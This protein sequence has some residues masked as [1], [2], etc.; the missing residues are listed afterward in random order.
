MKRSSLKEAT[1]A[2]ID[3]SRT[4]LAERQRSAQALVR[5]MNTVA[6]GLET[7]GADTAS[8]RFI[9]IVRGRTAEIERLFG[10]Q[11][12]VAGNFNL[13]LFGRTGAGK[14]TLIEALT[15]GDGE[16]VSHG[17]SDWTTKVE[18][19][20]WEYCKIYDTP[21]VN[22]WGRISKRA[23][24]ER[25]A[26][27]AVEVADFVLVCFDSQSQQASEFTK[28]ADWIHQ[29]NKPVVAVLNARNAVWRLPPRVPIGAARANL[30]RTVAEHAGNIQDELASVGLTGVPVVAIASK[31]ALFARA[32]SPF[33]GPDRE[34]LEL[35]REKYG[36]EKLEAW[37]NLPAL[38]DL[39]VRCVQDNAVAL[40]MGALNDQ[41][42]GVLDALAKGMDSAAMEAAEEADIVEAQTIEPL[43]KL[44]GYPSSQAARQPYVRAGVDRLGQLEDQRGPFQA[45]GNGEFG[46]FVG[47]RLTAELGALRSQSL[48]DAEE[49]VAC[50]FDR[51]IHIT[52]EQIRDKCFQTEAMETAAMRVLE[53]AHDFIT[54]RARLAYRDSV[55]NLEA[56][57]RASPGV[58]G[59]AGDGWKYGAWGLKTVGVAG[60]VAATMG[61]LAGLAVAG[62]I[63][64]FWNPLGWSA[65][66]AAGVLA[67]GSAIAAL[68]SW[69]GGRARRKAEKERLQAR[70]AA[71]AGV[72]KTVHAVYDEFEMRV[73]TAS[74]DIAASAAGQVVLPAIDQAYDLR[75]LC[76]ASDSI[77]TESRAMTR[78]LPA[79]AEPQRLVW[80]AKERC[81]CAVEP[82]C[83]DAGPR[84]WLGEAWVHDPDGLQRTY[85][86][87]EQQRTHAYDPGI[88]ESLF[89]GF[90][91]VW[92][93][94]TGSVAPGS[95]RRWLEQAMGELADDELAPPTLEDLGSLMERGRPRLHLVGDYNAGKTSFI[96]RLL[97]DAGQL[98]PPGLEVRG[99]PTTD[100]EHVIPW[101]ELDLV[102]TPGFQSSNES[103]TAAARRSFP[104]ASAILYLFQPNLVTGDDSAVRLVLNGD[105]TQGLVPKAPRTFFIINRADELGVDPVDNPRRYK[106][107]A[108][109]KQR[110]LSEALA[111]RGIAV[112]PARILCMASDPFELVGDRDDVTSEA[113]DAHRGW[114][115]FAEFMKA[116]RELEGDLLRTGVDRSVLEGG[117][118]RLAR[119]DARRNVELEQLSAQLAALERL[120]ALVAEKTAEGQRLC[121][122]HRVRLMRRVEEHAA[123]LRDEVLSEQD[124]TRL[125][126]KAKSFETWWD[127]QALAVEL[128]QWGK[129]AQ[130]DLED[131]RARAED[132]IRRRLASTEFK[133][134]FPDPDVPDGPNTPSDTKGRAWYHDAFDK[135][136]RM[137]GT[138]TRDVVYGIGKALGF[139]FRPWGAVK[140]ARVLGKVGAVMAVIGVVWDIADAFWEE[141]RQKKREEVRRQLAD[142]LAKT[143]PLIVE[144]I[145]EGDDSEPGLLRSASDHVRMLDAFAED[146]VAEKDAKQAEIELIEKRRSLY[147]MLGGRAEMALGGAIW[148]D[149]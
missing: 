81:E 17:E 68:F 18:P 25:R 106:E 133:E 41:L 39:L 97:L 2:A 16:S 116:Y 128:N 146:L 6:D 55:A 96:R 56:R 46:Q 107:L 141:W 1:K 19:K 136:G 54:R 126:I 129:Q 105:R 77:A 50:A 61:S 140:L 130:R 15:R 145:A 64:N 38:E 94:V 138:A 122:E 62:A 90:R 110:E 49:E 23:D 22:G 72:R 85:Q 4:A 9:E 80:K 83:S 112:A 75:A 115:G 91:D 47:Q 121:G 66:V 132:A 124:P 5:S 70:R 14:S 114:D 123:A 149:A 3:Q 20:D 26:R 120:V 134:A 131:W 109:R 147:R 82:T 12:E 37:S 57:L 144:A 27:N 51:G 98:V 10:A 119:L 21:G 33:Q 76:L 108:E 125:R 113:F 78:Q 24:L 79:K 84:H 30:T 137:V 95:G 58:D 127:D 71:L 29:F 104:D 73:T 65:A 48:T 34:T 36:S 102:D 74:Q 40:R 31:R 139:K 42:R 87:G 111:S 89:T 92:A 88:F 44:L 67:V 52:G 53:E 11:A 101:G 86:G 43:L 117:L 28:V 103:H 148:E 135:A 32:K 118:A 7:S 143:V 35:H 99:N 59:E 142:W 93:Q 45:P 100:K 13:V 8:G 69:L 63:S 60:G